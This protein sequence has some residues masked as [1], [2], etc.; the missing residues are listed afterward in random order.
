MHSNGGGHRGPRTKNLNQLDTPTHVEYPNYRTP[1]VSNRNYLRLDERSPWEKSTKSGLWLPDSPFQI[2][3]GVEAFPTAVSHMGLTFNGLMLGCAISFG[4]RCATKSSS[5]M[6]TTC[7]HIATPEFWARST[8]GGQCQCG[9]SVPAF[10]IDPTHRRAWKAGRI[11]YKIYSGG[12]C[13]AIP[14]AN[15][16]SWHHPMGLVYGRWVTPSSNLLLTLPLCGSYNK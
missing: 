12:E 5:V 4:F 2:W 7:G 16:V 15:V 11:Y 13:G 10:K 6:R 14:S 8:T 3:Y 1:K 9:R